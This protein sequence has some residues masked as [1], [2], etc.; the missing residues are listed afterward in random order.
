MAEILPLL[1]KIN[2]FVAFSVL[3]NLRKFLVD[4]DKILSA[5]NNIIYYVVNPAMRGRT[6]PLDLDPPVLAIIQ[7]MAKIPSAIKAWKTPVSEL[8]NDSRLFNCIAC[9]AE[10][11][12][13]IVK[14]LFDAD[15][16]AFPELL[17][18]VATAPSANI[19]TN[20]EYEMLLRSLN[21]RRLSFILFSGEKNHFLTQLPTI[22]EKL[23]D[24]FRN[25]TA[26]IYRIFEQTVTAL[27]VDGSEDLQLV[28]AASKCL[29][30]L[31]VLQTEEFQIHQWIF[32]TDTVDAI[33]RPDNWFPEAMMDQLAEIAGALPVDQDGAN[34]VMVP[35][36]STTSTDQHSLRRPMLN[37]LR[38]IESIRDLIPF[39]SN[40]SITSYESVYASGG[41]VDWEAVEQ[42]ILDDMFDGR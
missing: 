35:N 4:N 28:L 24:I 8:L 18:K 20:R 17:S 11:W 29:D 6:R 13:P 22:Q 9:V 23:V 26:P 41:N 5:C 39:F 3:P 36:S 30:L 7:A 33:Y 15:K 10:P 14:V 42:G 25:V 2:N 19:F 31:L 16:A 32:V 38:Q 1:D 21:V 12:T 37:S 34:G 40:V 27:P